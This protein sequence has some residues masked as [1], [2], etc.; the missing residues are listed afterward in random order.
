MAAE[1]GDS[2]W[3]STLDR[4][5]EAVRGVVGRHHGTV[6]KHTGDGVLATFASGTEAV[7]AAISIRSATADLGLEGRAGIHV[8]EV[9]LREDDIGGIAVHL[10]A[11]VMGEAGPGQIV[12]TSTVAESTL[13]GVHRFDELGE[14]SLKGIARPW[15]LFALSD[16]RPG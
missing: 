1:R 12:V 15:R 11:R 3:R 4:Y 7:E 5:D 13:G 10:A 8:G 6:V 9:E 16:E 14:R 2:A